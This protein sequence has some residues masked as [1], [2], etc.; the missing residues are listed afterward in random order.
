LYVNGHIHEARQSEYAGKPFLL[1]GS[2][3]P[4][5]LKEESEKPKG[6]WIVDTSVRDLAADPPKA[7]K[8]LERNGMRIYWIT[9]ENQR[10]VYVRSFENPDIEAIEKELNKILHEKHAMKPIVRLELKGK[11]RDSLATDLEMKFAGKVILSLKKAA[12]EK[13]ELPTKTLEEHKFSVEEM[14]RKVLFE[15]LT[16]ARLD[17]RSFES[18]F[19]LLAEGKTDEAT[20]VLTR[21]PGKDK[22]PK[23]SKQSRL[24]A[25]SQG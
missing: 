2:L 22:E 3:V 9:L 7:E 25:S 24:F 20:D 13:N 18:L 15:N 19:E 21:M 11:F 5:Q 23:N 12:A 16:K 8:T 6:F 17:T 10:K 1:S 14:G 4:T